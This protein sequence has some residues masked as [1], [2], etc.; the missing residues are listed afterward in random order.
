V[1][2]FDPAISLENLYTI[3]WICLQYTCFCLHSLVNCRQIFKHITQFHVLFLS[4]QKLQL[5]FHI[6][7][8]KEYEKDIATYR[9]RFE[10]GVKWNNIAFDKI[11]QS[12]F[13]SICWISMFSTILSIVVFG[14]FT[15]QYINLKSVSDSLF[16]SILV[17]IGSWIPKIVTD[18]CVNFLVLF[19]F[20]S[21]LSL[22]SIPKELSWPTQ[23]YHS[24]NFSC[25]I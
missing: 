14:F 17:L 16:K 7:C 4:S 15:R 1:L 22:I 10:Y 23:I 13:C 8:A 20:F 25:Q 18:F 6:L 11:I 12:S 24:E 3:F 21:T 5:Y 19:I 9:F 2:I